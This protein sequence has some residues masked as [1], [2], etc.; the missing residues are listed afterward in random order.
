MANKRPQYAGEVYEKR[1]CYNCKRWGKPEA[2]K[3]G[4][5]AKCN[6]SGIVRS[7]GYSCSE[8]QYIAEKKTR[9]KRTK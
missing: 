1:C 4:L 8:H 5:T 2:T 6:E 9:K 7:S 3:M